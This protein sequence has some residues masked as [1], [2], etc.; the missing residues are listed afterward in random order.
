MAGGGSCRRRRRCAAAKR[1]RK[2][3]P[4]AMGAPQSTSASSPKLRQA[5]IRQ[6]FCLQA[7][8][9]LC[10]PSAQTTAEHQG[11]KNVPW[12]NCLNAGPYIAITN[13]VKARQR[14]DARAVHEELPV[15]GAG[16]L[17][18]GPEGV[19]QAGRVAK[20]GE[21]QKEHDAGQDRQGRSAAPGRAEAELLQRYRQRQGDTCTQRHGNGQPSRITFE[22][23]PCQLGKS[24]HHHK[25]SCDDASRMCSC[26][27]HLAPGAIPIYSP[28]HP[29][30]MM[31]AVGWE[32]ASVHA[33]MR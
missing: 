3:Q 11:R 13:L 25:A 19:G 9:L 22:I 17:Q 21:G 10:L 32:A 7:T 29:S 4:Q 2:G 1:S 6:E 24:P 33:R 26:A 5:C 15:P 30:A 31:Y 18:G 16:G 8:G 23:T 27:M 12:G 28:S 20:A 14:E